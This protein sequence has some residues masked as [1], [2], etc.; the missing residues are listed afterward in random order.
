MRGML[1]S[2]KTALS[3]IL[4]VSKD[5]LHT[6]LGLGLFVLLTLACKG[7]PWLPW[8]A[9]V[10]LQLGNEALDLQHQHQIGAEELVESLRDTLGTMIWPT[11]AAIWLT[12]SRRRKT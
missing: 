5:A 3:D 2:I 4:G 1:N 7:R 6:H 11:V 12:M 8:I 9:V 10:L